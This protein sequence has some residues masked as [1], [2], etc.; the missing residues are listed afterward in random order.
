MCLCTPEIR[1][2]WCG[3]PGCEMPPQHRAAP[4]GSDAED[5]PVELI[6][7]LIGINTENGTVRQARQ[8]R[9]QLRAALIKFVDERI[10]LARN[11]DGT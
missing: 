11:P 7:L 10:A 9:D 2:P 5:D 4:L 6:D 1:T 8:C 3:K